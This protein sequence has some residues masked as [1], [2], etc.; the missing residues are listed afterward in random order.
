M[1]TLDLDCPSCGETL[2]LD[3]GFAGGVCRCSNCGTLMT[4][5]RDAGR[6]E[7]LSAPEPPSSMSSG[8]R[9]DDAG[10]ASQPRPSQRKALAEKR[11]KRGRDKKKGKGGRDKGTGSATIQAGEYR[12]ASG[13]VVQVEETIR[14]PMAQSKRKKIRMITTIVFLS[15]VLGIALVAAIVLFV[16]LSGDGQPGNDG[17]TQGPG[18]QT[19][20][21][22]N[23]PQNIPPP[24][25]GPRYDPSANPYELDFPNV[26]GLPIEGKV[27]IVVEASQGDSSFWLAQAG[28]MIRNGMNK[29]G[30]PTQAAL[31]A[32]TAAEPAVYKD[33][34]P[35]SIAQIKQDELTAWFAEQKFARKVDRPAALK[36]AL[37]TK[38]DML[39]F[40]FSGGTSD[41]VA[42]WKKL[43][44]D[45]DIVVHGVLIDSVSPRPVQTWLRGRDKSQALSLSSRQIK[46]WQEE[47][48]EDAAE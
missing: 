15:V 6:A 47:A 2:E 17:T 8:A 38:P 18:G 44:Q 43:F 9:S 30:K 41:E 22:G 10:G 23:A 16:M 35:T 37:E 36:R 42:Q 28:D 14:V 32:A 4:V 33:G 19:T 48:A 25:I 31:F 26:A 29:D 27:A 1:Q 34:K 24:I 12:T 3:A 7:Q 39:V 21:P 45:K 13:K 46:D 11:G 40:F 5:P 20:A